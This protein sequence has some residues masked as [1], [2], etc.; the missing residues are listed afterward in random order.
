MSNYN[1]EMLNTNF[2]AYHRDTGEFLGQ[3]KVE[4]P[5]KFT[6]TKQ[7]YRRIYMNNDGVYE[8]F[9][10][11]LSS[12]LEISIAV[13]FMRD[14]NSNG[15]LKYQMSHYEETHNTSRVT[16]SKVFT[17]AKKFGL[18]KSAGRDIYVNP[19]VVLPYGTDDK[20]NYYLQRRWDKIWKES[21]ST[22]DGKLTKAMADKISIDMLDE[23]Y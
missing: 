18:F 6:L 5:H 21:N 8:K 19:Y 17:K 23:V 1:S 12:S 13:D 10:K 3:G 2:D 15:V 20:K 22:S 9:M 4:Q 14:M 7:W 11:S 16:V